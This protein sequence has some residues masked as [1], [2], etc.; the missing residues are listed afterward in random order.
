MILENANERD[1]SLFD[2][3]RRFHLLVEENP[4]EVEVKRKYVCRTLVSTTIAGTI[5][6]TSES[7][8][9]RSGTK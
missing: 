1:Y 7:V 4:L 3:V 6:L 2:L 5:L 8:Y 9:V